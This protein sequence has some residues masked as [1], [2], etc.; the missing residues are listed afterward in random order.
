MK[1]RTTKS[2]ITKLTK[3]QIFVFGSNKDGNHAGGAAKLALE[4]FGAISGCAYGLQGKSYAINTMSGMDEIKQG[5]AN[6]ISHANGNPDSILLVT[7]IGCGI[8][9]FKSEQIAPLFEAAKDVENIHLPESFWSVL[10]EKEI[11]LITYKG[12]DENL[13]CL[14]F[15]YEIGK[16][17]E[18]K[19]KIKHCE[20]GFHSCENPLDVFKYYKPNNKNKFHQTEISRNISKENNGD[21]KVS[22]SKIKIGVE[23]KLEL[24]IKTGLKF[25]FEKVNKTKE[26]IKASGNYSIGAASGYSSTGA[27]S[28]YSSTGAA[29][30]NSSMA[31]VTGKNSIAISNGKKSKAKAC[32]G[33]WIV[34]SE[35]GGEN[36]INVKSFKIDGKKIKADI[37]Y[38]LENGKIIEA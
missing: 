27:A 32:L 1:N 14:N 38:K 30:G 4:K 31:I 3:N 29:S 12:F 8:A 17:F 5:I 24:L 35:Y 13:K 10:N 34:L 23:I 11:K 18:H 21:S 2:N 6:L 22:S 26:K 19:G 25:I 37:F 16:T 36:L 9:G 7:E 20:S 33:S 15:Q 28:G